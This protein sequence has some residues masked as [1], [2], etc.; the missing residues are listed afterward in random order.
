[1]FARIISPVVII[2]I[3]I[4]IIADTSGVALAGSALDYDCIVYRCRNDYLNPIPDDRW[5]EDDFICDNGGLMCQDYVIP[6]APEG[7]PP[8]RVCFFHSKGYYKTTYQC[9]T[10]QTSEW[11]PCPNGTVSHSILYF[12]D[13]GESTGDLIETIEEVGYGQRR[14]ILCVA[15]PPSPDIVCVIPD[16]FMDELVELIDDWVLN[17]YVE[18]KTYYFACT[19]E[20]CVKHDFGSF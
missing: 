10:S 19:E 7:C 15:L 5:D 4:L 16:W 11:P 12:L 8:L 13:A 1:M 2:V 9:T 17:G 6:G 14:G 3:C 18:T 20:G